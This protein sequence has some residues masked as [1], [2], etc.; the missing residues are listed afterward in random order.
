VTVCLASGSGCADSGGVGD[1]GDESALL[2]GPWAAEVDAVQPGS[3]GRSVVARVAV[4]PVEGSTGACRVQVD[5][6]VDLEGELVYVGVTFASAVNDPDPAFPDCETAPRDVVI[7]IG[8]PL[9]GRH[10]I[11]QTPVARWRP[12]S[13]AAG[14]ERCELPG[15]DPSTGAPPAPVTCDDSTLAEAVRSGDVP[16]HVGLSNKRCQLPWAVVDVD[17]GAGA[18]PATGDDANPCAGTNVRRTYWQAAGHTWTQVGSS[19]GAGCGEIA[20]IVPE[21]PVELCTGL[22]ALP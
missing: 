8:A 9:A 17:V 19:T 10:V 21:F 12:S 7:D 20:T 3:D 2:R 4:L 18:C 11:T 13:S 1:G 15:C 5:H 16:R 6:S 14:Y 22:P